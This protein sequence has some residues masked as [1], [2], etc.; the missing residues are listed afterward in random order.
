MK[1]GRKRAKK[2]PNS[3][4]ANNYYARALAFAK[5]AAADQAGIRHCKYIRQAAQRHLDDLERQKTRSFRYYF[6]EEDAQSPCWF[7]EQLP[8]VEGSW[9]TKLLSLEPSQLFI[10][11][12]VFGW[13]NKSDD[14]RRF[15]TVYIE[16][17]RKGAKS[18]LSAGVALYC[19]TMENEVGPQVICAATTGEQAQKVFSPARLM[20]DRSPDI[21]DACG[22]EVFSKS[23]MS[24]QNGGYIQSITS[25]GKTQ[26]GWNPHLAILDELHAHPDRRL[27]DVIRSAFGARKNTLL[28]AITTAG[29][30]MAGVCYDLRQYCCKVLERTLDADHLF[31]VIF[32][33]DSGDDPYD[34]STWIKANPL[35]GVTPTLVSMRAEAAD[36]RA[37]PAAEGEFKTKRLNMWLNAASAW[38]NMTQWQSCRAEVSFE[39]FEGLD[40]YIGA[41]LSDKDDI[42]AVVL[43]ALDT[44]GRLLLKPRFYLPKAAAETPRG[45]GPTYRMWANDGHLTLTE[46]DF[47]DQNIVEADIEEYIKRFSVRRVVFDQF[48]AAQAMASRLN[49]EYQGYDGGGIAVTLHKSAANVT[50]PAKELEARVKAGQSQLRHDGSPILSWMASNTVV[51]YRVDGSII[52]KKEKPMSP[53][54]ID[55]IDAAVNALAPMCNEIKEESIYDVEAR[56]GAQ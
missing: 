47:I 53:N 20:V 32:T 22:L 42:T 55:G 43:A 12:C 8:H 10:L 6:S 23:I 39:D 21:R 33:L 31:A 18:T 50:D 1:K 14:N 24:H 34:E 56:D 25:K 35:L 7:I 45:M 19:L 49:E 2:K 27:Y 4:D 52:P 5:D 16:M 37:S 40:C 38:L 36:A 41:D 13:R 3:A 9:A 15:S 48:G 54:K 44:T 28:W 11:C 17:A 30:N 51:S 46:G 26:D 29:Y